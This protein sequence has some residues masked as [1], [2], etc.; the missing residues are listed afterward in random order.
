MAYEVEII[1]HVRETV[2]KSH[3][4]IPRFSVP[5]DEVYE[6]IRNHVQSLIYPE[7]V[8]QVRILSYYLHPGSDA[9]FSFLAPSASGVMYYTI[10]IGR[11]LPEQL[12]IPTSSPPLDIYNM[13]DF[14]YG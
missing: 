12:F 5:D 11:K 6:T 13:K 3:L 9:S 2:C 7:H 14:K 4:H 10:H 1:K 8:D